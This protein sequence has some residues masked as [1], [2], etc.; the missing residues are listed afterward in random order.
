VILKHG[1]A[2]LEAF[3]RRS[4]AVHLLFSESARRGLAMQVLHTLQKA[5][6]QMQ[7][8]CSYGKIRRDKTL[9]G[10]APYLKRA[11]ER[12]I[13]DMKDMAS[14][15]RCL[16]AV[17]VGTLK[18]RH[19]DGSEVRASEDEYEEEEGGESEEDES[20]PEDEEGQRQQQ[21]QEEEE[22]VDSGAT[23]R[24]GRP[25]SKRRLDAGEAE[26]EAEG[27]DGG[28]A[29]AAVSGGE[30]PPPSRRPRRVVESSDESSN[31]D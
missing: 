22:E 25:S 28:A 14:E 26:E 29:A 4:R 11:L 2:F 30:P 1:R 12:L 21:D 23:Q 7:A 5:T 31:D 13:Y 16:G 19:M 24:G 10:E 8:I 18:H 3:L 20:Q 17:W 6:R 15:S 9:S 27:E